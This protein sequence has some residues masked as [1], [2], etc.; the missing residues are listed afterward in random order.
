MKALSIKQPWAWLIAN[1]YKDVENRT[2]NTNYRGEFLIHASG[3]FDLYGYECVRIGIRNQQLDIVDLPPLYKYQC[4][5][6]V[7][8][9]AI[10]DCVTEHDSRWFTGPYGFVIECARQL[11]FDKCKGQLKFF[12]WKECEGEEQ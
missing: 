6:I 11:N 10:V 2:W 5:G 7:G 4:G 8:I 1:G 3:T 12:D 9:A